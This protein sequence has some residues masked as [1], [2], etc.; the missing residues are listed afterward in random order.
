MLHFCVTKR[1]LCTSLERSRFLQ[2][3][4]VACPKIQSTGFFLLTDGSSWTL[5]S[6]NASVELEL[7]NDVLYPGEFC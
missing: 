2:L 1:W 3:S 4:S 6:V 5:T 7:F